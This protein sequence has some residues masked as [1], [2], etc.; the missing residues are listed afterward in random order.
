MILAGSALAQTPE[1]SLRVETASGRTQFRI[2]ETIDMKLTFESTVADKWMVRYTGRRSRFGRE[3]FLVSP[4]EG[5]SD[6]VAVRESAAGSELS[7]AVV[8]AKAW[9]MNVD[10]NQ[11]VR[12]ERPGRYRVSGRFHVFGKQ[13]QDLAVNSNEIE[14]EIIPADKDR[15]CGATAKGGGSS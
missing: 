6:P 1:V 3:E 10:L 9:S 13:G 7:G 4:K 2:G 11:W 12:F 5:T 14:I 15:A 8:L